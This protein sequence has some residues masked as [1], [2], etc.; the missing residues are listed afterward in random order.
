MTTLAAQITSTGILVPD[1]A[2]VLAQYINATQSIYGSDIV[3]TPNTQDGQFLGVVAQGQS[4]A[5]QLAAAA[6]NSFS[7]TY[8]QGAAL[9]SLVK[10]NGIRRNVATN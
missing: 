8:A 6:Y 1:Y 5:N 7:P 4:D 9:S 2:D 10:I 3:L